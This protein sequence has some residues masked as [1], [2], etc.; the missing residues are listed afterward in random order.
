[1]A[2]PAVCLVASCCHFVR[3]DI[4]V[5]LLE[6][7]CSS[8][9]GRLLGT[10]SLKEGMNHCVEQQSCWNRAQ[11]MERSLQQ[12]QEFL[13]GRRQSLLH[14]LIDTIS[15][16]QQLFV[17]AGLVELGSHLS[18]APNQQ[19]WQHAVAKSIAANLCEHSST[20][21]KKTL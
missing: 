13:A 21:R 16:R 4:K 9:F 8:V 7:S 17:F 1:M 14:G 2:D 6:R 12:W 10:K 19:H 20:A 15:V 18:R 11:A 5:V 3:A